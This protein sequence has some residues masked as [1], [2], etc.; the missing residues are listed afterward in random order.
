MAT[1]SDNA[2]WTW[3]GVLKGVVKIAAVIAV[4][5]GLFYGA[6]WG[7]TELGW[8]EAGSTSAKMAGTAGAVGA[9]IADVPKM[10]V[11]GIGSAFTSVTDALGITSSTD[12]LA[13]KEPIPAPFPEA[14]A[15]NVT[16]FSGNYSDLT[17]S[18]TDASSKFDAWKQALITNGQWET[19]S[20]LAGIEQLEKFFENKAALTGAIPADV[21]GLKAHITGVVN[22]LN[23]VG[24]AGIGD[25]LDAASKQISGALNSPDAIKNIQ[26]AE[27]DLRL[28]IDKIGNNTETLVD[29]V[30]DKLGIGVG[31]SWQALAGTG[32]AAAVTAGVVGRHTGREAGRREALAAV[33]NSIYRG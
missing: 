16:D 19:V 23:N 6:A 10:V 33:E 28:A 9:S 5:V 8:V 26:V 30:R 14:A 18:V 11:D 29:K 31:F 20:K 17:K 22:A 12:I 32:A 4:G 7:A 27:A 25:G 21:E 24:P 15:V 1:Q 13:N 3:G 2:G